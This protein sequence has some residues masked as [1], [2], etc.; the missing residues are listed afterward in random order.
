[1]SI[2]L[3]ILAY[4]TIGVLFFI[5]IVGLFWEKSLLLTKAPFIPIPKDVLNNISLQLKLQP[6]SIVY[7]L[8]CGDGRVLEACLKL[9]PQAKYIGIEKEIVPYCLAWWRLRKFIKTGH[10]QI[11]HQNFFKINLTPATCIFTYLFPQLM[12]DLLPKFQAELQPK[13]RLVSCDFL[14]SNKLSLETIDLKRS[15]HSLGK[16]LHIYEF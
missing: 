1:M 4:A 8:G 12:D 10:C 14:F 13:T 16:R 11:I 9:Q 3:L 7:D 2:F 6:D 5:I 15:P